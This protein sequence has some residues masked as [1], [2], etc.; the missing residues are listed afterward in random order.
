[1][2]IPGTPLRIPATELERLRMW[3]TAHYV[4]NTNATEWEA[5]YAIRHA[6]DEA[7]QKG[8]III[9]ETN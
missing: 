5:S 8:E 7:I 4:R 6:T 9:I 1:M 2:K 3:L